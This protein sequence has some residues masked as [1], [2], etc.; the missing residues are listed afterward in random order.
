MIKTK[1]NRNPWKN[2][3]SVSPQVENE[4][5]SISRKT[6]RK[7]RL[8]QF[9]LRPLRFLRLEVVNTGFLRGSMM[10]LTGSERTSLETNSLRNSSL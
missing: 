4:K 8:D 1:I 5:F 7:I 9:Q 6:E 10:T 3:V 2:K